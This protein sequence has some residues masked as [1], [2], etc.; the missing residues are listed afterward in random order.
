MTVT[1]YEALAVDMLRRTETAIDTI[2]GLS[3]DTG[4]TFKIS[5]IVQRVEDELP[6]DYPE[7]ST[8]DYTRRDM[9]AE[10]ARDLLS[11]EA[12]DE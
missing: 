4:I 5:D 8:G 10:M 6:A 3:V 2:A 12:Y 7:S 9:L 1:A 11:G